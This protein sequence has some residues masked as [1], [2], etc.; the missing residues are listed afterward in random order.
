MEGERDFSSTVDEAQSGGI[1]AAVLGINDGLV[2]NLALML[3][4]AGGSS[5]ASIVKLAGLASLVAGACSMAVGEYVSMQAQVELLNRVL[6]SVR[7]A[8]RDEGRRAVALRDAFSH[9]GLSN[10]AASRGARDFDGNEDA[11]VDLYAKVVLGI[12]PSELGSPWIAAIASLFT[13]AAGAFVPL[14]PWYVVAAAPA[15]I[16]SIALSGAAACVVG[17][18]LGYHTDRNWLRGA[19]RQAIVIGLAAGIT[20][21]VGRLFRVTVG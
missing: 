13:F 1:R 5:D 2:T 18:I 10:D 6:R 3:G 4:V 16:W 9:A 19:I 8:F 17:G 15:T 14:V 7:D 21:G 11:S 12:N 20:Y